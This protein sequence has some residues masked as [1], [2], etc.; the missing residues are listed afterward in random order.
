MIEALHSRGI[1]VT[2]TP[3]LQIERSAWQEKI[4]EL[5]SPFVAQL[6]TTVLKNSHNLYTEML[7]K[8][9]TDGTYATSFARERAFATTEAR[10][11]PNE[12]HFVDGSG[13]APDNLVTPR[14]MIRMLRWMNHPSRRGF[15]WSV[16][17]QP[18]NEGTLRRRLV[19]LEHRLRGKTG[20]VFGV[21]ALSGI[22]AMPD[23]RYRYFSMAVN[24]HTGSDDDAQKAID[25]MVERLAATE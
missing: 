14:A 15:W 21:I 18:A 17:A 12:F 8:R 10:V 4:A 25:A 11:A 24:H 22:L 6:L 1:V 7:F 2:G 19:S 16:L 3:R 20:T 23:G 5:P 9:S 13:L